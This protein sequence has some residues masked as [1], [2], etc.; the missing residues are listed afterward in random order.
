MKKKIIITCHYLVYGA[1]QALR[2]YLISEKIEKLFFIAHPLQIDS[3]RSYREIIEN[4]EIKNKNKSKLRSKISL[5]NYLIE[6][7]LNFKWS[8]KKGDAYDLWIGVDPLNAFC[9]IVMRKLRRV[10]K[11][12]YYT[13][14]Y[15]PERFSNKFLNN[16]YHWLDK[17]CLKNSDETWN[18]SYRIAEGREKKR[19][20]KQYIYNN[21]VIVPIGIWFNKVKRMSFTEIK[22]H[23]LLFVGNLLEKQGVQ[24]VLEAMPKIVGEI[25]DFHFLVVGGGEYENTLKDKVK[26][27][28]LEKYV[29]FTGWIK[30]RDKL[31]NIMADSAVAIAMYD[32]SKDTFTYYADPTK[33][34][35]YLSAGLPILLTDLPHNAK[36]IEENKCGIIIDYDKEMISVAIIELMKNEVRLRQY[37]ENAINYIVK[38]D[39]GLIF[40]KNLGRIFDET[41]ISEI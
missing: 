33:L 11:V 17:F 34:K 21:Q 40:Q 6:I 15:V 13:I 12:V 41:H 22:K 24:L 38:F 14:D 1:P 18:V 36:E 16:I 20:L 32:K 35:D 29:T 2:E 5:I 31:D 37:R 8:F 39:W 26:D 30:E 10:K 3:T 4:G 7:T 9:G 28:N 27:L 23:Q 19:G 25:S